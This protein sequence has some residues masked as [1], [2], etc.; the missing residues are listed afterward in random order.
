MKR[1]REDIRLFGQLSLPS[2]FLS[3]SRVIPSGA[4][5]SNEADFNKKPS[6]SSIS[7]SDFLSRK[8]DKPNEKTVQE[9]RCSFTSVTNG[10]SVR[11]QRIGEEET[12][13]SLAVN[14]TVFQHFNRTAKDKYQTGS[15]AEGE[16]E[17]ECPTDRVFAR[18]GNNPFAVPTCSGQPVHSRHLVVLGD[19]PKPKQMR[20]SSFTSKRADHIFNHYANGGGWWDYNMEGVDQEEVGCNEAW[21][22]IG[23]TTIGGLEWH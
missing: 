8:L 18:K 1:K 17:I 21:E 11:H 3:G 10:L 9:R 13:S 15:N 14:G 23:A 2:S 7:L 19:D 20:G 6:K 5:A 4:K 16:K 22:S 12:L